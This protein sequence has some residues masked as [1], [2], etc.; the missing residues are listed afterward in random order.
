MGS[1]LRNTLRAATPRRSW[2]QKT[3]GISRARHRRCMMTWASKGALAE[4]TTSASIT[5]SEPAIS[6]KSGRPSAKPPKSI[7][8]QGMP[9]TYRDLLHLMMIVSDNTAT[10]LVAAKV[11]FDNVN[12]AMREL[13]LKK[14]K[15][16]RYCREILFDLVGINDLEIKEVT[17]DVF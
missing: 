6:S 10:D 14:T 5:C 8:V 3:K 11:G 9:V 12:A 13:G 7:L 2:T 16:T 4:I 17:L 15:V 1:F